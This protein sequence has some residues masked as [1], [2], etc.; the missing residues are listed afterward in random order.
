[1]ATAEARGEGSAW[2]RFVT[3]RVAFVRSISSVCLIHAHATGR[4]TRFTHTTPHD[5][6]VRAVRSPEMVHTHG[7]HT[8]KISV[9]SRPRSNIL[10][11]TLT[12]LSRRHGSPGRVTLDT[13]CSLH[14]IALEIPHVPKCAMMLHNRHIRRLLASVRFRARPQIGAGSAVRP[15]GVRPTTPQTTVLLEEHRLLRLASRGAARACT[16]GA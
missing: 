16:R 10:C 14:I 2:R 8:V 1:M 12:R 5:N 7:R 6:Y 13:R 3:E 15:F 11:V 4:K 9:W